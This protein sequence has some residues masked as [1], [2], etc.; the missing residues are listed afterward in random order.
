M[1]TSST[2]ATLA[3]KSAA[4]SVPIVI[5]NVPHPLGEGLVASLAHPDGNVA[6]LS[7]PL[8]LKSPVNDFTCLKM[9]FRT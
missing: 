8:P 9:L 6:G 2:T 3:A 4:T 5:L 1:V 7:Q